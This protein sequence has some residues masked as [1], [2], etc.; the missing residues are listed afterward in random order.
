[1]RA[2]IRFDPPFRPLAPIL[3]LPLYLF[4]VEEPVEYG[5]GGNF[6]FIEEELTRMRWTRFEYAYW[7]RFVTQDLSGYVCA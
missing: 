3:L 7:W 2:R 4:F 6:R 1:M 5:R